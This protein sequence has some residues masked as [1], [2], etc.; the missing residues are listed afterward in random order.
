[1]KITF[2]VESYFPRTSGVPSVVKYLAEGLAKRNHE[3]T[4][5]TR[6][7]ENLPL[8]EEYNGVTIIRIKNIDRN[9]L[10]MYK[11]NCKDYIEYLLSRKDDV[12][13]I[14]CCQAITTDI[15]LKYIDKFNGIKIMH[16]H[17]FSGLTLKPFQIRGTLKHT[18]GNTYNFFWWRY[19]YK[20]ILPKYINKFDA[21][22]SLCETDSSMKYL[23]KKFTKEKYILGNAANDAFFENIE[24]DKFIEKYAKI[25]NNGYFLSVANYHDYKNQIGILKEYYLCDK[26][27]EY[28]M[29][30]IG[31]RKN[32]YYEKLLKKNQYYQ[33]KYKK[34]LNV[35]FLYNVEKG[36][37]PNIIHNS[38]L[39]LVGSN[40]EEYSISIIEAMSQGI[41]FISTN[42]GNAKLL[43]GGTTINNISEM[44]KEICRVID[45]E[46][47]YNKLSLN[48]KKFAYEN[49]K[50]EE[51]VNNL[52]KIIYK[53]IKKKEK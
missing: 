39:Y 26:N 8:E 20:F 41:P 9:F 50:I 21:T 11:S 4:V 52:E 32:S 35:H 37:I 42:V 27:S 14:E 44:N 13:I 48:G 1:M 10:K 24:S 23:N 33:K 51:A 25:A 18:F 22:I 16:A 12:L 28:D 3:V 7:E 43:P 34:K 30:F 53:E 29:V 19:Y 46:E 47:L 6:Y 5:I 38:K 2:I 45:D 17:G 15:L 31:S 49:C 36:D 40:Y